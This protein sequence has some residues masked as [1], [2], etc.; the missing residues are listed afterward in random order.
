[1]VKEDLI[2]Y[3]NLFFLWPPFLLL[4]ILVQLP[5]AY[6]SPEN[7]ELDTPLI[8]FYRKGNPNSERLRKEPQSPK[9]VSMKAGLSICTLRCCVFGSLH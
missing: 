3:G 4:S 9:L 2:Q 8:P 5:F 7:S 6:P 1:M